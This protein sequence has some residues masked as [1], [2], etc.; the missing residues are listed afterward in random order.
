MVAT[1]VVVVVVVVVTTVSTQ[2]IQQQW[3]RV[4]QQLSFRACAQALQ[5]QR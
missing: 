3:L 2:V 5:L 4:L 1:V